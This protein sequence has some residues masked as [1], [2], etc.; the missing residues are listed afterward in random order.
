MATPAI[1]TTTPD[2]VMRSQ[3]ERTQAAY[4]ST[5]M[6]KNFL[7]RA[8]ADLNFHQNAHDGIIYVDAQGKVVYA[9]PYFLKMMNIEDPAEVLNKPLPEF[10]WFNQEDPAK[11]FE[12]VRRFGFVRER[13]LN[14]YNREKSAVFVACSAVA[15][16]DEDG[17]IVGTEI[18]LCNV[19]TKKKVQSELIERTQALER[20]TEFSRHSIEPLADLVRR[21]ANQTELLALLETLQQELNSTK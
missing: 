15:S 7:Q 16:K 19:T 12:D 9:N 5:L 11:L 17:G 8:M 18:M 6:E 3:L 10:M 14:L 21:G 1:P 20:M 13:E 2:D 4:V